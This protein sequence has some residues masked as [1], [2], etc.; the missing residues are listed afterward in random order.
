MA[1]DSITPLSFTV[2]AMIEISVVA[3]PS[4]SAVASATLK[5]DTTE[6]P[7]FKEP[8][9]ATSSFT[10]SFFGDSIATGTP[11]QPES[12]P[13]VIANVKSIAIVFFMFFTSIGGLLLFTSYI[14]CYFFNKALQK[15]SFVI[16][17]EDYINIYRQKKKGEN[18]EIPQ[19][20]SIFSPLII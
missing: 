1:Q 2:T 11:A 14:F 6:R 17:T 10:V 16:R 15:K 4:A 19:F 13:I 12:N 20:I 5:L 9:S 18:M 8:A 7:V 3:F